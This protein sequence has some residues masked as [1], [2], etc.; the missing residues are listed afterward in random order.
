[1]RPAHRAVS[2]E[3]LA[4]VGRLVCHLQP[5]TAQL[6]RTLCRTTAHR[7]D[8]QQRARSSQRER[9]P[10]EPAPH[11]EL[12]LHTL[13]ATCEHER[14]DK[15]RER[16]KQQRLELS[17]VVGHRVPPLSPV[18]IRCASPVLLRARCLAPL[19]HCRSSFAGGF[20]S[21]RNQH[22]LQ[23]AVPERRSPGHLWCGRRA[24][25]EKGAPLGAKVPENSRIFRESYFLY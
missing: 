1:M 8:D 4:A 2:A 22:V 9:R 5:K 23:A 12:L 3:H 14:G 11:I 19:A 21:A 6:G 16:R 18:G 15:R 24:G 17:G 10:A 25:G 7:A 13:Q 20:L